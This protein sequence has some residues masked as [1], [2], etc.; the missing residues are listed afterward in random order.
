MGKQI[1]LDELKQK[2]ESDLV[3]DYIVKRKREGL[4]SLTLTAGLP[5]SGK[6]S[7]CCRIAELVSL[8][9]LGENIMKKKT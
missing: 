8:K 7:T 4:Y 1:T 9:I 6:T 3:V 5:G 2:P